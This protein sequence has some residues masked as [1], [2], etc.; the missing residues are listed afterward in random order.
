[1]AIALKREL[2]LVIDERNT[3]ATGKARNHGIKVF[4]SEEF[5]KG[6]T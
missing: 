4:S 1:M 5:I 3:K 2:R 6:K